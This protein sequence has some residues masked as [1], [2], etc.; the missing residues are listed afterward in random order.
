[1]PTLDEI[2]GHF[3]TLTPESVAEMGRYYTEDAYFKDPH[4]EVRRLPDIQAVFRRM[5]EQID[6]PR[7]RITERIGTGGSVALVWELTFRFR[8]LRP[9][10]TQVIRGM[11]HLRLAED[12][13]V[14]FH[15]DYWDAAE[16]LYEKIPLLG[17]FMRR[18]KRSV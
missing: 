8:T 15:R 16:E 9:H 7:L 14:C 1:M 10:E 2:V 18:I 4:N 3:E 17:V 13:R 5:F 12:G 11:S 6:A